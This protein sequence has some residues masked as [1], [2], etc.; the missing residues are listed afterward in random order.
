MTGQPYSYAGDD[1][2]NITDPTGLGF[3]LQQFVADEVANVGAEAIGEAGDVPVMVGVGLWNIYSGFKFIAEGVGLANAGAATAAV[4]IGWGLIAGGVSLIGYGFYSVGDGIFQIGEGAGMQLA[5][6]YPDLPVFLN[7][8]DST[9][10][11]MAESTE[12]AVPTLPAS[13]H[14]DGGVCT[15]NNPQGVNPLATVPVASI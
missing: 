3:S 9:L 10:N 6:D 12:A 15:P 5:L 4:G 11:S 8:L 2:T 7:S 13:T 14:D 1:P